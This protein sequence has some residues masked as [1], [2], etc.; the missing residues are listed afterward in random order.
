M[1]RFNSKVTSLDM[2]L[3]YTLYP[4]LEFYFVKPELFYKN[5]KY[6]LRSD[7][8]EK[9]PMKKGK[10]NYGITHSLEAERCLQSI[11][12]PVEDVLSQI[13]NTG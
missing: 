12:V 5:E 13:E 9:Y 11:F 7:D 3:S 2:L 4:D 10:L 8:F 1:L 6:F